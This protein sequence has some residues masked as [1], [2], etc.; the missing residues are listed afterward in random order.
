MDEEAITLSYP[1]RHPD[2]NDE[3]KEISKEA[4]KYIF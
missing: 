2:W 3:Y 4:E 1:R